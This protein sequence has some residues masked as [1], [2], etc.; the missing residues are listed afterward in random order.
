M[1][2]NKEQCLEV[3][4]HFQKALE[5]CEPGLLKVIDQGWK[6][7]GG[8]LFGKVECPSV[9]GVGM[10]LKQRGPGRGCDPLPMGVWG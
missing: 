7:G 2:R 8:D 1:L 6:L 10:K 4:A 9:Q 3:K 5:E